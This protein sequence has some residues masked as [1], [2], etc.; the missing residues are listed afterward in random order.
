M[1]LENIRKLMS[2]NCYL[3]AIEEGTSWILGTFDNKENLKM[4]NDYKV[5]RIYAPLENHINVLVEKR[6]EE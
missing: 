1:T 3:V 5:T 4:F 6:I 2:N